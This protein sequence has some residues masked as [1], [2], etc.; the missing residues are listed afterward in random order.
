M[1]DICGD[2]PGFTLRL[3]R[4]WPRS[5]SGI[6]MPLR[7]AAARRRPRSLSHGRETK[8]TG[9]TRASGDRANLPKLIAVT[10]LLIVTGLPFIA[11]MAWTGRERWWPGI[12][13]VLASLARRATSSAAIPLAGH[14]RDIVG[15]RPTA[16]SAGQIA[17]QL[18]RM[19][20]E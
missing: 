12:C 1:I 3:R 20:H 13:N 8:R 10:D 6:R 19:R 9:N 17:T 2:V 14:I 18:A 4:P 16:L 7:D 5:T 11:V 15:G